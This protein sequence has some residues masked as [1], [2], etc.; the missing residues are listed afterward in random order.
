MDTK[1]E[2]ANFFYGSDTF[3]VNI[4]VCIRKEDGSMFYRSY[5]FN[6]YAKCWT[7][8]ETI[9][10]LDVF[11]DPNGKPALKWGFNTLIGCYY[12]GVRPPKIN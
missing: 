11:T 3:G 5:E 4:E 10:K 6:G 12:K 9:D 1:N 7:K 2:V 8:W